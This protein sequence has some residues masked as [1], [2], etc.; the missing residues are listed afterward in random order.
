MAGLT[1]R[2]AGDRMKKTW[3]P[4]A[5]RRGP[6]PAGLVCRCA[7]VLVCWYAGVP[8]MAGTR[9]GWRLVAGGR[10]RLWCSGGRGGGAAARLAEPGEQIF[11][12]RLARADLYVCPMDLWAE[13]PVCTVKMA[14]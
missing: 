11:K 4:G 9:R 14:L 2:G 1:D 5:G 6:I 13:R 10:T 8:V 7:G 12:R 3:G